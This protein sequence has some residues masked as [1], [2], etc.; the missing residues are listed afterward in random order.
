MIR[1]VL[2]IIVNVLAVSSFICCASAE[3]RLEEQPR[4]ETRICDNWRFIRGDAN[5]AS[6]IDFNDSK[7]QT[8]SLPHTWNADDV[9]NSQY[10]RGPGWYRTKLPIAASAEGKRIFVRFEAASIV[11]D[12]YFNGRHIGRHR[13]A[14]T[15]FC[16]ELTDLIRW[17]Q[18]NI[19]AV[20]VDNSTFDDVP[21]LSGDFNMFGGIYRPVWLVVTNPVCITPLDYGSSGVY[22]RQNKVSEKVAEVDVQ[23][24]VSGKL[25]NDKSVELRVTILDHNS[26]RV[27]Q[28]NRSC[29]LQRG[30]TTDLHQQV[31]IENPHLWM[32]RSDPYLYHAKVELLAEG[33]VVDEIVQPLGLR[34]FEVDPK[35]GFI[36]NGSHYFLHGVCRHQDRPGKGWAISEQD[37]DQDANMICELGANAVRCAH[38]PHSDY[39]YSLCDKAGLIAWAEIPLV[40]QVRDTP[41]FRENA[42]QQLTELIRQ[43][44]NH[45]SII[46]WSLYNEL[47]NFGHSDDPRTILRELK[48]TARQEDPV[49]LTVAASNDGSSKWPG[50]RNI[51]DLIVWNTYPG[52]Y[53]GNPTQMAYNLDKF[54]KDANERCIG[55]SEYG[56]GASIHQHEQD[57][58]RRPTT[59]GHWHPEEWQAVVHELNYAAIESRPFVW[60]SFA[61]VMFDFSSASRREGDTVGVNDKGLVTADR[62]T[63]KD[64]FYFYKAKWSNESVLYIT[65]RRDTE[66]KVPTTTVKVYSNCESV[67]LKVNGQTVGRNLDGTGTGTIIKW[68]DVALVPGTNN[69][70]VKGTRNGKIYTDSCT[71]NYQ[72]AQTKDPNAADR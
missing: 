10:Y 36:L 33:K 41:A 50:L 53:G 43:R 19:L 60:G 69:I 45:P 63:R 9:I 29:R 25:G 58:K 13:G 46:F 21:P 59:S 42:K 16:Y 5:G 34:Y 31:V 38:Y 55:V 54:Y 48:A 71:W 12:V 1:W 68:T 14:F 72:P 32:G 20:R 56:A 2:T 15:A 30:G 4:S 37:Q 28:V 26:N 64:A 35:K 62:K 8:V 51:P 52:W 57:M 17:G 40:D 49:R 39:F 24:K 18:E 6:A 22:L 67:E 61:W 23:A 3:V 70:K 11:A 7:W 44:F 47:G 27:A 65:S 66:R